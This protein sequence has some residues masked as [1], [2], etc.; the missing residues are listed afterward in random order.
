MIKV[1]KYNKDEIII[2]E[3]EIGEKAYFIEHGRVEV[4]RS[5]GDQKIHLAN[6]ETGSIFGEMSMVDEKPRS[7]TVTATEETMVRE[8]HRDDFFLS[9]SSDPDFA[10]LI[11][12]QLFERLRDANVT[13]L[14]LQTLDTEV[15]PPATARQVRDFITAGT[16]VFLEGLTPEAQLALP[17]ER[18]QITSFPYHIGRKSKDPLANNDLMLVTQST[19]VQVS[20][21][22]VKIIRDHGKIGIV[23]RG[24]TLG[25][26]VNGIKIGG[27]E[28][29]PGP[30]FLEDGEGTL[31]LGRSSSPFQYKV[32]IEPGK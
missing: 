4:S 23:D 28:H 11:L 15:V 30:V 6:L 27:Q 13:I 32:I 25:T 2:A 7:A 20:R 12:K 24:S 8:I 21:H 26:I 16:V 31:T 17:H 1:Q 10:V 18:F 5:L 19:P 14:Q 3:H 9:F 29:S 22:H